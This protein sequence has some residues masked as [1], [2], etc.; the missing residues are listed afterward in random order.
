[1]GTQ[2]RGQRAYMRVKELSG[3]PGPFKSIGS[4]LVV[5]VP[6]LARDYLKDQEHSR[7]MAHSVWEAILRGAGEPSA[8]ECSLGI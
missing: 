4:A 8:E 7:T 5:R 1:M 3:G 6:S 2:T